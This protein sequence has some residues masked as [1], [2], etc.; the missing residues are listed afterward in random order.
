MSSST[1]P[2]LSLRGRQGL[3]LSLELTVLARLAVSFSPALG[4]EVLLGLS[5]FYMGSRGSTQ[6]PIL[7]CQAVCWITFLSPLLRNFRRFLFVC[8]NDAAFFGDALRKSR[9]LLPGLFPGPLPG[10]FPGPLPGPEVLRSGRK[11]TSWSHLSSCTMARQVPFRMCP[12]TF[13]EKRTKWENFHLS[14]P[15][16]CMLQ[17]R[18]SDQIFNQDSRCNLKKSPGLLKRLAKLSLLQSMWLRVC[19]AGGPCPSKVSHSVC[20][21]GGRGYATESQGAVAQPALAAQANNVPAARGKTRKLARGT[22][23]ARQFQEWAASARDGR[24]Q[25][26]LQ[27]YTFVGNFD[28]STNS[29]N[30]IMWKD[31]LMDTF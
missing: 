22:S 16:L 12:G 27:N 1:V 14:S 4:L 18:T 28:E 19:L 10:P 13:S 6:V 24:F 20:V 11:A 15:P 25:R 17:M 9:L 23:K 30:P 29:S 8:F 2:H 21:W 7:T 5:Y 31:L 3:S 26:F